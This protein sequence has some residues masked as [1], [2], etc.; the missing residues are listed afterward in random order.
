MHRPQ[1]P[2]FL[3]EVLPDPELVRSLLERHGPYLPVQR[4]AASD[5]EYGALAGRDA[6]PMFVASTFRG[7]W[8]YDAPLVDGVE[9]LLHHAGFTR[10]AAE[11]L[12][13][14]VVRPQIVYSN[15]TYQLPFPQGAGHVDVPAFR[16]FDRIRY[17]IWLLQVMGHSRLF[18]RWRVNLVTA[19]AWFY[20]GR[21]GGFSYWP[22]GPDAAPRDHE[23]AIH[24]TAVVGD[25]DFMFHR[26]KPLG[27]VEDGM[28]QGLS[29]ETRL[30]WDGDDAWRIEEGGEV[31]AR[32][33]FEELRVSVSWKAQVFRDAKEA[34]CF[35]EHEDDL[36]LETVV[37]T[38]REDLEARG[39]PTPAPTDPLREPAWI[40]QLSEAYVV[41]PS[42]QR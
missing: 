27:R 41:Q 23:G 30:A 20:Q 19:V 24:N 38:L 2:T 16:G 34:R 32:P 26:V 6:G 5:A 14:E 29:L 33:R 42:V 17:P 7:D 28:L 31:K 8:A 40:E 18:E 10:A 11:L 12:G 22:D 39:L 35:D 37:A 1:P 3:D 9:P 4:Y 15:I 13:A 36:D 25:N 21:D